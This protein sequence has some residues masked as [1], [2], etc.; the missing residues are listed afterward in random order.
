MSEFPTLEQFRLFL[1]EERSRKLTSSNKSNF[2]FVKN[3]FMNKPFDKKGV[4]ELRSDLRTGNTSKK[5]LLKKTTI[6][7]YMEIVKL[8][9][10]YMGERFVEDFKEGR[11]SDDVV[12]LGDL[13]TD[14][15]MKRIAAC[16]L[17]RNNLSE[18]REYET[19]LKYRAMFTCM[20]FVGTPPID[21]CNMKWSNDKITHLQ[22][23]RQKTGKLLHVPIVPEL[24]ELLDILPRH[25]HGYIF[26]SKQGKTMQRSINEEIRRRCVVLGIHKRVTCYSFRYSATQWSYLNANDNTALS[27]AD[28][29]GHTLDTAKKHYQK[30]DINKMY[31]ALVTTHPG[32]IQNQTLDVIKRVSIAFITKLLKDPSKFQIHLEIT[33]NDPDKRIIHLS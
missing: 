30:P 18:I 2:L 20:R 19:N 1:E 25:S 11:S 33:Y 9:G 3:Y 13:I 27:L 14:D 28:V 23:R 29:F 16:D 31:D 6:K 22:Y 32:L 7:K 15:E 10:R 4:R 5:I 8:I 12:P 24:R 17:N 21:I 26:A